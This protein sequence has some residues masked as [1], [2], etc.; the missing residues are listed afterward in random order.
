MTGQT[1]QSEH[2]AMGTDTAQKLPDGDTEMTEAAKKEQKVDDNVE[3]SSTGSDGGKGGGSGSGGGYSAD[4]SSSDASSLEAAKGSVPE[5]EMTRLNLDEDSGKDA[6][7]TKETKPKKKKKTTAP[8]SQKAGR[9]RAADQM[10]TSHSA[11]INQ[12]DSKSDISSK[13]KKSDV[14]EKELSLLPQW[15]GVRI[16]HPMDPR[17]DLS[18]VG[19][20]QTSALSAFPSNVNIPANQQ[21]EQAQATENTGESSEPPPPPS[22]DQYMKLMEVI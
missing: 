14:A 6:M 12:E 21:S 7:N 11:P 8:K 2:S 15:N 17:I 22:I 16:H 5:K 20:I 18:T 1:T 9:G 4:C 13:W 3:S 19:Y 10:E